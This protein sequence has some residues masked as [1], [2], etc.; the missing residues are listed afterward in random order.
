MSI[1]NT[2]PSV[3]III[4]VPELKQNFYNVE[5]HLKN[6]ISIKTFCLFCLDFFFFFLGCKYFRYIS[7]Q[8]HQVLKKKMKQMKKS[9]KK[10]SIVNSGL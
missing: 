5:K 2:N 1:D 3:Y 10:Y 9:V 4:S 8:D 6:L 7:K